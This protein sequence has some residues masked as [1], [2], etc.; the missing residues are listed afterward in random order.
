MPA[1]RARAWAAI[2]DLD[3]MRRWA[4][5]MAAQ[6]ET[7]HWPLAWWLYRSAPL[8]RARAR[9]LLG[10]PVGTLELLGRLRVRAE[11][12]GAGDAL[13]E[14]LALEALALEGVGRGDA[15][16]AVVGRM[17]SLAEP[18]GY[19]RPFLDEGP[20]LVALVRR[21]SGRATPSAAYARWLLAAFDGH[22]G[23]APG[24]WERG[25]AAPPESGRVS[26]AGKLVEPLT[27][28]E[29]EILALTAEGLSNQAIAERLFLAV[30]TIKW[31]LQAIYGKLGAERRTE[32]VARARAFGL[33]A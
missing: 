22:S 11:A 31:H 13:L 25:D 30:G 9:L 5:E 27:E 24:T 3:S 10:D 15:A 19:V 32:A 29:L 16:L 1:W 20:S 8:M 4:D 14:V 18:E 6:S 33:I 2:G 12:A 23:P 26:T 21:L 17:L 7:S 28:R